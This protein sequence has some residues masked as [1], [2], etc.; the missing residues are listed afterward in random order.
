[1]IT[2]SQL[3]NKSI[4]EQPF[5]EES[6]ANGLINLSS[7]ARYI[8]AEIEEAIGRPVKNAAILMAL[9]RYISE[10]DITLSHQLKKALENLGE[11]TVR[12]KLSDFT[13]K[14]S[15]KLIHKQKELLK[16][17]T[18]H[19]E[20]FHT[21]SQGVYETTFVISSSISQEIEKIFLN[22]KLVNRIDN[23]SSVTIKLPPNNITMTGLYYHLLK[24]IAWAKINIIEVISTTN[25]FT[26]VISEN[27]AG[28]CFNVLKNLNTN[29]Y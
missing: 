19:G 8:H 23:L 2:I 28:R 10:V 26:V 27:D 17:I 6:M 20:V 4:S 21:F 5:M 29:T 13:Y 1:M 24:K 12:S 11:I 14:N 9:K 16:Y 7:M 15:D 18:D 3:V 22:E 25:E